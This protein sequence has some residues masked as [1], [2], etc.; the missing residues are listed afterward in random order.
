LSRWINGP[1]SLE[2]A[3]AEPERV[4]AYSRERLVGCLANLLD[5]LVERRIVPDF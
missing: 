4:A 3:R 5:R 2:G 1:E